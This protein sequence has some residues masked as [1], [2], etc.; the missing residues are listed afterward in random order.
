MVTSLYVH[1][2]Y[3]K[4]ICTYCDFCKMYYNSQQVGLY[5]DTMA[6]ELHRLYQGEALKT[7]YIGG[8]TPSCLSLE[9]LVKLF[10]ILDRVEKDDDV[11][12]TIECNFDSIT[13][14]K[15]DLFQNSGI[16]RISFGLE[17][18]NKKQEKYLGRKN[19]LDHI[20][21]MIRYAKHIGITNINVDLIYALKNQTQ[22]QLEEDIQFILALDVPHIS[23]YSLMIEKN[24]ILAI[25]GE[26]SID[27]EVDANMYQIICEQLKK[28]GY[29]HYEISN[30]AKKGYESKH[31]LVYWNNQYY[32][33]IGLGA[34][35]YY[36]N[37]RITNT[38][39]IQHY[40]QQ[41]AIVE[42]E[43]ISKNEAM[44]YEVILGLR[45]IEG[46][47][48]IDFYE[49]YEIDIENVFSYQHLIKNELLKE[50]NGYLKIPEDRLYIS[51]YIIEEFIYGKE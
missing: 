34:S 11:E 39:S 42:Q 41:E 48:K 15:L 9:E 32:Y 36:P 3:C 12:Y 31:N 25:N 20:R 13:K 21:E 1:I 33:G 5:L 10:Q 50:E 17:T 43:S 24:T 35:A 46:I 38:R 47:S 28:A 37:K 4:S 19:E 18:I 49:K 44:I 30:F 23:T 45:L 2:P 27:P 29:C 22:K 7:I 14:E 8:G 26:V 6:Q 51:N 40:L 16:N